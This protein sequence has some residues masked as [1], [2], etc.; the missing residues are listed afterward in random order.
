MESENWYCSTNSVYTMV[1]QIIPWGWVLYLGFG[2]GGGEDVRRGN[3]ESGIE[4]QK[5]G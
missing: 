1:K 3:G 2:G 4:K 5:G